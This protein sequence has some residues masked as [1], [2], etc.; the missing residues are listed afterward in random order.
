MVMLVSYSIGASNQYFKLPSFWARLLE[1]AKLMMKL[2]EDAFQNPRVS[3]EWFEPET[4]ALST[5]LWLG[6][7]LLKATFEMLLDTF[8]KYCETNL[9][10]SYSPS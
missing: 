9:C 3:F 2:S 10:M 1:A 8:M 4:N 7:S 6:R 5:S